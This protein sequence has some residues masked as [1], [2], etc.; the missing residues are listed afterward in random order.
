MTGDPEQTEELTEGAGPEPEDEIHLSFMG[1][2]EELRKRIVR[3]LLGIGVGVLF[4]GIFAKEIFHGVMLPVMASL[5]EGQQKLHYTSYIEPFLVYLKVAIYGGIFAATPWILWQLWLFVAPGLY[6]REK[7]MV[8]P[9]IAAGTGCFYAGAAACYFFIM[10]AAF[11]ALAALAGESMSP[12][13]TMRE[14]LSLV[15]AMLLGFAVVFEVPVVIAFLAML[16]IVS[17]DLLARWRR[18]AI[19]VNVVLAAIITPTADPLNLALM[20][21][22]M[23]VFYEVGILLAKLV[24]K[25]PLPEDVEA[26]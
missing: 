5:P 14:Q 26:G 20:A 18:Y 2:L 19:V 3:S 23:I 4:A 7:K 17:A 11:P 25:K 21:L 12:I 9:F 24:G 8:I 6:R 13:L 16:G 1:H 15:L 10:P 22:P